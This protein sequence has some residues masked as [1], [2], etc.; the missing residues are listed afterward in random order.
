MSLII[1]LIL[2]E[3]LCI[4]ITYLGAGG[5]LT[6]DSFQSVLA[7]HRDGCQPPC[8]VKFTHTSLG[9]KAPLAKCLL[10]T[11]VFNI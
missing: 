9:D 2:G 6:S 3:S 4:L 8:L 1:L 7:V 5:S 10:T 11:T